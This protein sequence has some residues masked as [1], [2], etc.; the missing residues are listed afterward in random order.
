ML[1]DFTTGRAEAD[2]VK[3]PHALWSDQEL[4][5]VLQ[6]D[7]LSNETNDQLTQQPADQI[8]AEFPTKLFDRTKNNSNFA[9]QLTSKLLEKSPQDTFKALQKEVGRAGQLEELKRSP[10]VQKLLDLSSTARQSAKDV[11]TGNEKTADAA[12]KKLEEF[13][14]HAEARKLVSSKVP[15]DLSRD[16]LREIWVRVNTA[17]QF[18][19]LVRTDDVQRLMR[20]NPEAKK[21]VQRYRE[22]G[23]A[24]ELVDIVKRFNEFKRIAD[25]YAD[26]KPVPG[27]L[28]LNFELNDAW[29][30]SKR[31]K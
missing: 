28:V 12:L 23:N 19:N 21:L 11:L 18:E 16:E 4:K 30:A 5:T 6:V 1:E 25:N 17:K 22:S 7:R 2:E 13:K 14:E 10:E 9:D 15:N 29:K 26:A 3:A 20:Q 8:A 31:K 27:R 24:Q